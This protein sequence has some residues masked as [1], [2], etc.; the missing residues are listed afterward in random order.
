MN[1]IRRSSSVEE[2]KVG[3]AAPKKLV[4]EGAKELKT[5]PSFGALSVQ[6]DSTD[7]CSQSQNADFERTDSEKLGVDK[8]KRTTRKEDM[9]AN[10]LIAKMNEFTHHR[11]TNIPPPTVIHDKPDPFKNDI[12][13]HSL[14]L[15]IGGK[16]LLDEAQLKLVQGRKYGLVGR[17]GIGKTTLVNAITRKEIEKFPQNI[18]ILQVEQEAEADDYTVLEHVMMCDVERTSLLEE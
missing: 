10:K 4:K 9:A 7:I 2:I 11:E 6:S 15:I 8:K 16:T 12:L 18:H 17:N 13:I 3:H 5:L 1:R 14:T